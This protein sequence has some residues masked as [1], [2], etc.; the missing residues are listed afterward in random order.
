MDKDEAS[1]LIRAFVVPDRQERYLALLGS[2]RG[3]TKVRAALAHFRDLDPRYARAMP[4]NILSAASLAE[5]LGRKG[6]PAECYLF[7]EDGALDNRRM[8]LADALKAVV[9]RGQGAF[10]SCVPRRLAY[11]EGEDVGARYLLERDV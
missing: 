10:V 5:L 3:R 7:T 1:M 11:F 9:G 8:P 2:E 4:A 6:A